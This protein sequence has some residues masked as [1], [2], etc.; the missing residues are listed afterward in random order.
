MLK[1]SK[2]KQNAGFLSKV[3]SAKIPLRLLI[4]RC[5]DSHTEVHRGSSLWEANEPLNPQA[6][7]EETAWVKTVSFCFFC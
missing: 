5:S 1:L 4:Y 7:E 6:R 2:Y 3:S